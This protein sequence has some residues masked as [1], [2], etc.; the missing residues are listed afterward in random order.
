MAAIALFI[1]SMALK[2]KR[3]VI[4]L[5]KKLQVVGE[6]EKGKSQRCVS[7]LHSIPKSTVADN[8]WKDR[9]KIR[10]HV[11]ASDCPS[12]A[13]K[14]HIVREAH[15]NKLD[16]ACYLLFMQQ[17]TKGAPV[18]GPLLKEKALQ[19]FPEVHPDSSPDL[20]K[21][22]AGWLQKFCCR[23]GIRG[24]SLQGESLSADTSC[25][26][27]LRTELLKKMEDEGYTLNQVFNADETGLWW[28]LMPSK[29]LV[30]CGQKTKKSKDRVTLLG[31]ANASGTCKLPLAF[32]H[33]PA[34][35]RCFKHM[36]MDAL[37]VNSFSQKSLDGFQDN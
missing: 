30:H 6:L 26:D 22:S 29:T 35:P 2:R 4:T 12:F 13:K 10:K 24:I 3:S 32:I 37:P 36:N 19:L 28:R 21:A 16:Q 7:D 11:S 17:R 27:T 34:K 18:S 31:C 15:F 8:I 33:K 9:E 25:I 5:E 20:F 23:H 1:S 14:R